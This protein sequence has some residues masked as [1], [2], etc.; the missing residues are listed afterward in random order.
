MIP[1]QIWRK[2]MISICCTP[3]KPDYKE[4]STE[5]RKIF[6]R[7]VYLLRKK[8]YQIT[9]ARKIAYTRVLSESITF[10]FT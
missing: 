4:L 5:E 9:A 3:P 2:A 1:F 6:C 7:L 10:Q 8:G